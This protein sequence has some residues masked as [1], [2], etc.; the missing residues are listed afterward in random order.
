ME[1]MSSLRTE[2]LQ[3]KSNLENNMAA[4]RAE[5]SNLE[6]NMAAFRAE[7]IQTRPNLPD[8]R[9][10]ET[11]ESVRP[12]FSIESILRSGLGGPCRGGPASVDGLCGGRGAGSVG[13]IFGGS[14]SF[15]NAG[16]PEVKQEEEQ[17]DD[18]EDEEV[19]TLQ[20][21]VSHK[22]KDEKVETLQQKKLCVSQK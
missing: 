15:S 1:D 9:V 8:T 4:F 13:G 22:N 16:V 20:N 6:N 12:A 2:P 19:W 3:P 21:L 18:S 11:R 14:A 5:K 10:E 17:Q 7:Q